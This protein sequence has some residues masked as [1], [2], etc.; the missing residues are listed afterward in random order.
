[1]NPSTYGRWWRGVALLTL[2]SLL[3]AACGGTDAGQPGAASPAASGAA[4]PAASGAASPAAS[5]GGA[6]T[7]GA[8]LNPDVSGTVNFWHFWGSPVRRNAI[9]R[10]IAICNQKLPNIKVTETFKPFGDIWTAN[11]AAVA[12]GS[13]MP[14][15][16][17]EDRPQLP[18]RAK[19]QVDENLQELA[20]RDGID[21]SAFWP[22]TWQQTLYEDQTYGIPY[23]TDVRVLYWNKNAFKEVGLDPEKP[24]TTWAEVEQYADKLD[25]KNED[26]TY[27]RIGFHPELNARTEAFGY[28]NGVE[29]I[30]QD[31]KPQI[32]S[33][34]AVETVEWVKKWVDRYGGWENFQKFRGG[35]AAPPQDAF[36]SGKVAMFT[37][38]NGYTSQLDFYR[39]RV[40]NAEGNQEEMTWGVS[41]LPY[42]KERGST[43]GGFALSIPRGAPNKDAAWEFIKCATGPDAQASWARDTYAMPAN[44]AAANDPVLTADPRWQFFVEAMEHTSGGVYLPE[45]P[46]WKE[47]LEQRY[48]KIWT[49]ELEPKAALDEAQA[50]IDAQVNK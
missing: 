34:E 10:V 1:M 35:F 46:N 43:S 4:S 36:M 16:I 20:T 42:N 48:E 50:A 30:S 18:L 40:T 41:Y 24:P 19:D 9:R 39:P 12:A 45:Y 15:V 17:V 5:A 26:G 32:N 6:E 49:G 8:K 29:W 47:Q 28:T 37:D 21:G 38:I 13:G 44:Q 33:P 2:M 7:G 23:E 22:F 25:K 31:G 11:I 27:A 14:D 3:L